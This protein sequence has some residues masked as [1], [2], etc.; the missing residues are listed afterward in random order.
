MD[1]IGKIIF[2]GEVVDADDP[3]RLGRIR[4]IPESIPEM[5]DM[6]KTLS[7]DCT[8]GADVITNVKKKCKW[9]KDD[10]FLVSPLLPF[11]INITPK[12][13]ELVYIIYPVVQNA[14]SQS[15]I[16][17]DLTKYYIPSSPST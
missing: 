14:Q 12:V 5:D 10:P 13:G 7:P 15:R 16:H 3:D 17:A 2:L 1:Q 9:T 6:K 11:S 4:F 8:D